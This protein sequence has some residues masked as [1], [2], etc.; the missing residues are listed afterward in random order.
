MVCRLS[1][2]NLRLQGLDLRFERGTAFLT[3]TPCDFGGFAGLYG[4]LETTGDLLQ[5]R[6]CGGGDLRDLRQRFDAE[7]RVGRWLRA[8]RIIARKPIGDVEEFTQA[9]CGLPSRHR[10][11]VH[12]GVTGVLHEARLD[13]E[14]AANQCL[15]T[16]LGKQCG[17]RW[18]VGILQCTIVPVKPADGGLQR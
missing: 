15:K 1:G 12:C 9:A 4:L 14:R 16:W 7:G 6:E 3:D 18:V 5:L 13:S 17:Q 2:G 8:T 11:A 10:F